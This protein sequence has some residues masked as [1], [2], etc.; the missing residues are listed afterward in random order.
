MTSAPLTDLSRLCLHTITTKPW[1]IELAAKHYASAG[2]KGI[3]VWR[4]ALEGRNIEQTG[5][6]LHDQ[7]LTIVSLCRGG[8]F[9]SKDRSKRQE[10]IDDNRKVIEEASGLGTNTIVLVCGA[11]P[12]QSL[13]ESRKQIYDGIAAIIPEAEATGVRLA[14]EPLHPMYADVR[15]AINTL[16][17]AN[18]M[19]ESLGSKYIGV[20]IE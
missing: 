18:D 13:E 1:N 17:Q 12:A 11:D 5:Q 16:K 4:D 14:I 7:N 6:M 15:S 19:A 2:V 3:T 20:R 10:A 8:F 9:A